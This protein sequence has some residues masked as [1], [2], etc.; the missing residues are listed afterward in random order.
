MIVF[1]W[2]EERPELLESLSSPLREGESVELTG[3]E[4]VVVTV[5]CTGVPLIV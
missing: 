1:F 2:L 3:A 5:V 4:E